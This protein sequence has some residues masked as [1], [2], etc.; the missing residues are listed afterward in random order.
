MLDAT[1]SRISAVVALDHRSAAAQRWRDGIGVRMAVAKIRQRRPMVVGLALAGAVVGLLSGFGNWIARTPTYTA[2]SQLLVSNTT[3]QL[4][5]P[6]AVVTQVLVENSVIQSAMEMLRSSKVLGRVIDRAG[7]EQIESSLPQ[8][9][10]IRDLLSL[11]MFKS[12][13]K[14]AEEPRRQAALARLRDNLQIKRIGASQVISVL[15][16]AYTAEGAAAMTNEI[17]QS[18][19]QEQNDINAVV[20]TSAALRERIKVLGPT[21][22]IISEAVPPDRTDGLPKVVV[23]ALAPVGGAVAFA[24]VGLGIALLDRRLRSAEQLAA[25]TAV[26]CLGY[27]P[28]SA[29]RGAPALRALRFNL[30]LPWSRRARNAAD[31]ATADPRAVS[32]RRNAILRRAR[33]I[34]IERSEDMPKIIGITSCHRAEGKTNFVAYW[35]GLLAADGARVLLVDASEPGSSL[36]N[37]LASG[38]T[39][40][41]QQLLRGETTPAEA[42]RTEIRRGLDFLPRGPATRYL[43]AQ[44]NDLVS[45]VRGCGEMPY[46]WVIIDLPPLS[47]VADVRAAGQAVDALL[48]VVEWGRTTEAE[49]AEALG[50]LG[51]VR[52]KL[53]ATVISKAPA[54]GLDLAAAGEADKSRPWFGRRSGSALARDHGSAEG[55]P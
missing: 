33:S 43:D 34:V 3:L 20:S 8:V 54:D 12:G 24:L 5:G 35:A 22:R 17:A 23:L 15:C 38:V 42:I 55:R 10:G 44:W 13:Q 16:R 4:S 52:E 27:M 46:E 53:I 51:P 40:G 31:D 39:K 47:P 11:Q 25:L 48:V 18:F 2:S 32:V 28:Q 9:H 49:L 6:D 26:E 36:S 29:S 7:L 14:G 21:A 45:I 41:L 1:N 30:R 50:S 19:V 37:K